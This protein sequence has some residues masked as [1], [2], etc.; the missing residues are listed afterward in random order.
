MNEIL[1]IC[2][3][4]GQHVECPIATAGKDIQC[5]SCHTSIRA[6]RLPKNPFVRPLLGLVEQLKGI[7]WTVPFIAQ[8]IQG[9]VLVFVL[10]LIFLLAA[11][12]GIAIQVGGVFHVL[13]L[14]AT[15]RFKTGG[16][17]ERSAYAICAG[18]YLL[19][20]IPFW[21]LQLPFA[22]LGWLW[23]ISRSF[24]LAIGL[25][26]I[27]GGVYLYTHPILCEF[28]MNYIKTLFS[29]YSANVTTPE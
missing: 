25:I 19:L 14:D 21:I 9:T 23:T 15:S 26:I 28:I 13:L 16:F 11:T 27:L 12:V 29:E 2:T 20:F 5:P 10:A 24:A 8:I 18:I 3:N 6:P 1:A 22:T 4:C 7:E 17:A